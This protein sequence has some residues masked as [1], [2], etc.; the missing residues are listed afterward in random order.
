M[1]TLRWI[2]LCG[3]AL[4][5]GITATGEGPLSR[6]A[7]VEP[8]LATP[9]LEITK[10]G[11]AAFQEVD[12]SYRLPNTTFPTH[13]DIHLRSEVHTGDR[14][15]HGS[16]DIH[17]RVLEPSNNIVV[18]HRGLAIQGAQIKSVDNPQQVVNLTWG[19]DPRVEHLTLTS[20]TLLQSADYIM[21][22]TF[23][24]RL[25]TNEDG[26]YISSYVDSAGLTKYLA[27]TQFESTSA[28][29]AFPCYDE[30]GLKATFTIWITHHNSYS[31]RSNMDF[32][33][34][35]ILDEPDYN[36]T[37]FDR[38]PVMSTYLLAF[39]VSD[40]VYIGDERHSVY[41]RPNAIDEAQFALEAGEKVLLALNEHLGIDYYAHLPE[42]KQFA[43]PDFAAGAMENWGLVTYREQYLL[44]NA[45][46]STYR[47]KT[48]IATIIAHEYAH[49][50]FGNLVSP[51]WWE[52]IWL[53]EGFATLYEYYAAHV[54]YP[55]EGYWELFNPL[56]I[57]AAMVP[58]GL[59]S[60]R[61]M[62]GNA[63]S[64][65]EI[66][67]LFDRVAYP[68]SG[69]VLN[70][71]RH[72]LGEENWKAGLK[73]YLS[74][75]QLKNANVE[76]LHAGLQ[77]AIEG[78]NVLPAGVSVKQ[79]MDTWTTEKG[80]PVL[81]VRR[82]YDS[83]DIILS[84]ERFI[85][86]RKVPNSNVWMIPFN[87]AYRSAI[88]FTNINQYDWLSTKAARIASPA[89]ANDWIIFNKQQIGFY[90]V[91]YDIRNW[92]LITD[93]MIMDHSSI[94]RLNR[95][96]LIDDAYWLTRS[97]RLDVEILMNLIIYLRNE[98]DYVPWA[99][100]S[101][102]LSYLNGK[103]RGTPA[104]DDFL[105][106]VDSL[107]ERA[108]SQIS[109]DS[110]DESETVLQK[111]MKQTISA[112]ACIAARKDCLDR[113]KNALTKEAVDNV[114]VH[115]DIAGV[116]Y[117]YGLRNAGETEFVHLYSRIYPTQNWAFR[118]MVIDALGCSQNKEF[119]KALLQTAIAPNGP[120]V[121]INYKS[122]ERTRIVQSVYSGG[123]AG[124]DA[125]IEFLME[126]NMVDEFNARLG[127]NTLNSVVSNIAARTNNQEELARLNELLTSL[128]NNITPETASNARATVRANME[129][130]SSYE[131]LL[132]T[133]F[134]GEYA[135]SLKP[136]PTTT[137]T[138]GST[139]TSEGTSAVPST[140][141]GG[142]GASSIAISLS[143][144]VGTIYVCLF[145]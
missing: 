118:T 103:L 94:H 83:G 56:V 49:Q 44:F 68:K 35:Q 115:P 81:S 85:S 129:W 52:Y 19:Y 28:R 13:Y 51:E 10:D 48:N 30:P 60:T 18:H 133:N 66:A 70:M 86:D 8:P 117:C 26:F 69:S 11:I 42:M 46:L 16:V 55:H 137:E 135:N 2:L 106:L 47:T 78:K 65:A 36:V 82:S 23:S 131:G 7:D 98:V 57:Q 58:D 38:T 89:S 128:G 91:N 17:L 22:I 43:I 27:T 31:A 92:Q 111:N 104:Y 4:A 142:G 54:A 3:F 109:V 33:S 124:C 25:A 72:V 73:Y 99:A 63:A 107:V 71:I 5:A 127:I 96:Q 32:S 77:T 9:Q 116:V 139:S 39:V 110:V 88:D 97:G 29:M 108:Y 134:V 24:G 132:T 113:T 20:Q 123:R 12:E 87:Y 40:F 53:N 34:E 76:H 62:T 67:R 140:T 119:L 90:R 126:P 93:A 75:R 105:V 121:E 1:I 122:S 112:W 145:N 120:G 138:P 80:Y 59:E 143:L 64:P 21:T 125:L 6:K 50:W 130:H 144:L 114:M 79:I 74:E 14:N 37:K 61:P 100:A 102:V 136:D 101:N 95:A 45:S 41:T 15:F 141:E 84:Q